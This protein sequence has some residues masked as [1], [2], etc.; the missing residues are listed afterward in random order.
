MHRSSGEPGVS[1]Y[2]PW[3]LSMTEAYIPP[4]GIDIIGL[5]VSGVLF[6]ALF[7]VWQGHL[8]HI[9]TS[10]HPFVSSGAQSEKVVSASS[11]PQRSVIPVGDI[12]R[13]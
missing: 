4:H 3:D 9:H 10:L 13:S 2:V 7:L 5:F 12:D 11:A 6:V 8:E 1:L